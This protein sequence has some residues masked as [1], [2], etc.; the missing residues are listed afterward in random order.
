MVHVLRNNRLLALVAGG[1]FFAVTAALMQRVLDVG[2]VAG[3]AAVGTESPNA[4]PWCKS[5]CRG[6]NVAKARPNLHNRSGGIH[7][8]QP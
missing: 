5:L 3:V 8:N 7:A 6:G 1:V 4:Q 2:V